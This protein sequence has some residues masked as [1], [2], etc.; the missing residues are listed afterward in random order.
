MTGRPRFPTAAQK[1][2]HKEYR[3]ASPSSQHRRKPLQPPRLLTAL[4]EIRWLQTT[5][6]D[7]LLF[8]PFARLIRELSQD[9]VKMRFTREAIQAFRSGAEA[10]LLEIFEKVKFLPVCMPV[11]A[12]CNQRTFGSWGAY[13]IMTPLLDAPRRPARPGRWTSS[14]TE[15]TE[16]LTSKPKPRR[17]LIVPSWGGLPKF[18]EMAIGGTSRLYSKLLTDNTTPAIQDFWETL[19][20]PLKSS[21]WLKL[22]VLSYCLRFLDHSCTCTLFWYYFVFNCCSM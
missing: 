19:S 2:P 17:P 10:Y 21:L 15:P 11:A 3:C 9:L 1:C 13:W 8:A 5:Y 4:Q 7:I 12:L 18:A 20:I 16:L 6:K 22:P 14:S